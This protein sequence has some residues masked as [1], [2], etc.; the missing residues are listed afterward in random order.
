M[1]DKSTAVALKRTLLPRVNDRTIDVE[2][3][4][5][6]V[7]FDVPEGYVG[8]SSKEVNKFYYACEGAARDLY[9]VGVFPRGKEISVDDAARFTS[10]HEDVKRAMHFLL[11][12][13]H[14]HNVGRIWLPTYRSHPMFAIVEKLAKEYQEVGIVTEDDVISNDMLRPNLEIEP[15][16]KDPAPTE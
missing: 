11:T 3:Q 8:R 12:H 4:Q 13:L 7:P 2:R 16:Y 10:G 1:S 15:L 9:R 14:A 5:K 6:L